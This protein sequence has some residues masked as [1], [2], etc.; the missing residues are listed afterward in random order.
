MA[1]RAHVSSIRTVSLAVLAAG[2]SACTSVSE[3]P[4][5]TA[6]AGAPQPVPINT[7]FEEYDAAVLEMSPLAKSFRGIR[8]ED[9]SRWG[10]YSD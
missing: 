5:Q 10:D 8:D 1:F 7:V 3:S 4:A 6:S 2:L 9:Y